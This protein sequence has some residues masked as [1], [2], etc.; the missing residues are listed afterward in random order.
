MHFRLAHLLTLTALVLCHN[1]SEMPEVALCI[2][3]LPRSFNLT[4]PSIMQ[5]I[6]HPLQ[7]VSHLSIYAHTYN[8]T[9]VTNKRSG[10]D[11]VNVQPRDI[12]RLSP[13]VFEMENEDAVLDSL[14][15]NFCRRHGDPWRNGYVSFR[16]YMCQ[17]HSIRR[18]ADMIVESK[19]NYTA[20]VFARADVFY[21]TPI[22][23]VQ[24]LSSAQKTI[25]I[26]H[27]HNFG[28]TND[29]FAFGNQ[30]VMLLYAIRQSSIELYCETFQ[31]HAEK[32]LQ[33]YLAR[34]KITI[35]RTSMMFGRVRANGVLWEHPSWQMSRSRDKMS[36]HAV[37]SIEHR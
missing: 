8:I 28:A 9:M 36:M 4:F 26:P 35:K 10:E 5:Y 25:Y 1:E 22:D 27:F 23:T 3:G 34:N 7:A 24:L 13:D 17:L 11:H 2:F 33:W 15:P 16:N 37:D 6:V 29:R 20:V 31:A 18:L 32:Y 21:F 19:R 12:L 14:P 30:P